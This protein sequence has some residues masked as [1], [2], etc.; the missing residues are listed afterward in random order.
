[1]QV[2]KEAEIEEIATDSKE[3]MRSVYIVKGSE[4][5]TISDRKKAEAAAAQA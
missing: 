3:Q 4:G 5:P 1:M 2:C